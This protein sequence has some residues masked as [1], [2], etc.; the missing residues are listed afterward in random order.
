[1]E[2]SKILKHIIEERRSVFPKE[3]TGEPIPEFILDEILSAAVLAPN[4][5]RTK[6]WR[7]RVFKGN[8]KLALG[9]ELQ[10]VYKE[11]TPEFQFLQKKYDDFIYKVERSGAIISIVV[12]YSNLVPQ[13]EE[14][15][16]VSMAV[17]N[18]YLTC[19]ANKIGCYWGSPVLIKYMKNFLKLEDNQECLGFLYM[20]KL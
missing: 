2:N 18:M 3:Y 9:E 13:W 17:Q 15:A 11:T 8:E 7:F 16:A 5:K 6:P 10:R 14:I 4:H 12:E 19:T 1:M 20:G